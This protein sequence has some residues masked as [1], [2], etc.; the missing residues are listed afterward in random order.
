MS[1]KK[2]VMKLDRKNEIIPV[3]LQMEAYFYRIVP[4]LNADGIYQVSSTLTNP[5]NECDYDPI[6]V[7]FLRKNI[8]MIHPQGFE[9]FS[10]D[11]EEMWTFKAVEHDA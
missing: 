1:W 6:L 9:I 11:D 5:D 10:T 7:Q 3:E 8:N 2:E 4:I